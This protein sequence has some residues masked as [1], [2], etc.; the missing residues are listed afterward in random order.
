[1]KQLH[2]YSLAE[3]KN[4]NRKLAKIQ[5]YGLD[6]LDIEESFFVSFQDQKKL[7]MKGYIVDWEYYSEEEKAGIQKQNCF[8]DEDMQYMEN[9]RKQIDCLV[10]KVKKIS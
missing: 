1:M 7:L 8:S 3:E 9:T 10:S 4:E 5:K 6:E 2:I